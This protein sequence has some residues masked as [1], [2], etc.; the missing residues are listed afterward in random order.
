MAGQG[1]LKREIFLFSG[2]GRWCILHLE[3]FI[4]GIH[5]S[6]VERSALGGWTNRTTFILALTGSAVGL[7]N[8]WRF[9]YLAGENGGGPF[10]LVYLLSLLFVA[11]PIL[12]AEVVIG[13]HGRS[14]PIVAVEWA[15]KRANA[16]NGWLAIGWLASVTALLILSYYSVVA[17]WA[18]AYV[19]KMQTSVFADASAANVGL[20]FQQFLSNP[21]EL[22]YWQSL[23][24]GATIL[25]VALGLRFGLA[26][27][28]WIAVPLLLVLLGMLINFSLEKGD[29]EAAQQFLFGF[30]T[31]DF[32]AQS[33]LVALGHAFYTLSVGVG[34]AMA[35][36]AYA[37]EKIPIGR[38]V[39]AVALIDTVIAMAAGLAIFPIIFAN[40]LEPNMGPGLM[41]VSLP[42]AFGN[43]LQGEWF[44]SLFFL[45]V[46]VAALGSAVSLAEPMVAYLIQVWRMHR[47][48]AAV[49]VG[50]VVW[51][52]G[53]GTVFSFNLWSDQQLIAGLNYFELIDFVTADL[54]LPLCGLLIALFVGWVL[55]REVLRVELYREDDQI[56]FL[57]RWLLRYIAPPAIVVIFVAALLGGLG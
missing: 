20:Q 54:L 30:N 16:G 44:G 5:L 26:L 9:S 17:G 1:N 52:L 4:D 10:V 12:V 19:G 57:W 50:V 2:G 49:C 40:N 31:W 43:M 3:L 41:F 32:S 33:V 36:G 48:V 11:T 15:R 7:G 25:V 21:Q 51:V 14:S 47:I 8:I 37:P 27:L 35:F 42:Y 22:I 24:L 56:F 39:I 13:S 28:F 55:R 34:A 29:V 23:F 38:T 53:L 45:L 6:I 46:A 18:L